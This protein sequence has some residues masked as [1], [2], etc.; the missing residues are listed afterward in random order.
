MCEKVNGPQPTSRHRAAHSCGNGQKG[1]ISPNH[2]RWKTCQEIADGMRARGT[3]M[4]G[5]THVFAKV[6]AND[7]ADIRLMKGEFLQREIGKIYGIEQSTVSSI[8][9]HKNWREDI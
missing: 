9:L 6:T 2:L 1:C 5:E 3:L 7:V 4:R 8:Q